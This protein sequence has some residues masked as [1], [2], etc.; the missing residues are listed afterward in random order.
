MWFYSGPDR[1]L[2]QPAYS[3]SRSTS[4]DTNSYLITQIL[5]LTNQI[6]FRGH[7]DVSQDMMLD[8]NVA[9]TP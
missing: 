3:Q 9:L 5:R 2:V 6:S 4:S 7:F 8:I 1:N